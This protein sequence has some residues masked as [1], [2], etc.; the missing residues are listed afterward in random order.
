MNQQLTDII[1]SHT[2]SLK[3]KNDANPDLVSDF[4]NFICESKNKESIFFADSYQSFFNENN[5]SKYRRTNIKSQCE[6]Y[7]LFTVCDL[8]SISKTNTKVFK[9]L[10]SAKWFKSVIACLNHHGLEYIDDSN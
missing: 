3:I 6:R 1:D 5:T 10:Q 2:F 7:Q 9:K 4:L 8:F